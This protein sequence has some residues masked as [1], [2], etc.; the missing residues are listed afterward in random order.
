MGMGEIQG[1]VQAAPTYSWANVMDS[2]EQA[3]SA[4]AA[5]GKAGGGAAVGP[6]ESSAA[7]SA[8]G[9]VLLFAIDGEEARDT[10]HKIIEANAQEVLE[11][12]YDSEAYTEKPELHDIEWIG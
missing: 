3:D 5:S 8:G 1:A 10:L 4:D 2:A 7:S 6:D 11:N 12:A 9:G